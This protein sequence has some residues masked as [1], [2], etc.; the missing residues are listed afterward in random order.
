MISFSTFTHV[1]LRD[2]F[3]SSVCCFYVKFLK[4]LAV[5]CP[6]IGQHVLPSRKN[7]GS[8]AKSQLS[9]GAGGQPPDMGISIEFGLWLCY[10]S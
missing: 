1:F 2:F 7:I 4:K 6:I 8:L 9:F 10:N 3:V 5:Q